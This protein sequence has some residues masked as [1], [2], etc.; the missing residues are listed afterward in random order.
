[1]PSPRLQHQRFV[2]WRGKVIV[3]AAGEIIALRR[4]PGGGRITQTAYYKFDNL[5]PF[6]RGLISW[7]ARL[8]PPLQARRAHVH[9]AV[10]G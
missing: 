5:L 3:A 1:M 7:R 2:A 4:C 8:A 6:E 10:E 9:A